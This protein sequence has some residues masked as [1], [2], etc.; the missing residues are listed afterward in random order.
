VSSVRDLAFGPM[1]WLAWSGA[2][3]LLRFQRFLRFER[4]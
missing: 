4:Q 3:R 1:I 2:H